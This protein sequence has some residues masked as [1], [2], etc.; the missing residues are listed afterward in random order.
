MSAA[1]PQRGP[2]AGALRAA[3]APPRAGLARSP[4]DAARVAAERRSQPSGVWGMVLFLG[5]ESMLFAGLIASYFY[6]DFRS[7]RWPPAGVHAPEVFDPSLLTGVLVATSVPVAIAARRARAGEARATASMFAVALVVQCGYLAFQLHDF[8]AQ[9]R[10]LEPRASAYGSAYFALLGLHHAH[11]LLGILL[12][13]GLLAWLALSGL[14]DYRITGA[15][16]IAIYWHVVNVIAVL[17]LLTEISP[18]L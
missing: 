6:L 14:T 2:R 18:S 7:A 5:A 13:A 1:E 12:E 4:A 17:V 3:L 15:R 9:L 11:V 8:V 10:V 16:A